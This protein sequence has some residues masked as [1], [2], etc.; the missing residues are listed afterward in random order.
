MT[1]A[2]RFTE[3]H[4]EQARAVDIGLIAQAHR[5]TL[6][7]DK[8]LAGPCPHC[9]G[10]DRF[11]I[12]LPRQQFG[13]RGCGAHGRGAIDLLVFLD[14]V[15]FVEAVEKLDGR[16][17]QARTIPDVKKDHSKFALDIF[18]E[19][20]SPEGTPV[21]AYLDRRGLRPPSSAVVRYHPCCP[22]GGK[23]VPAMVALVRNITTNKPQAVHRTALDHDGN[24]I[25]VPVGDRC[26]DRMTLAP[27]AGGAIKFT[28]DADVSI[29]LGIGEGIETAL[30]LQRLPE[31]FGSPVWSVLSATGIRDFPVL[32]G[33]ETLFVGVDHDKPDSFGRR[34]GQEAATAVTVRWRAAGHDVLLAFPEIEDQDINDVMRGPP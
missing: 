23:S 33:I 8:N 14:G 5:L 34:A 12:N 18:C 15:P 30:S 22:F 11:W 2:P 6:R 16:S 4:V 31:W 29:A 17:G 9:G 28:A 24:K 32:P 21:E 1:A 25:G 26:F 10:I 7:G 27:T 3:D 13:C 19:A 20:Q